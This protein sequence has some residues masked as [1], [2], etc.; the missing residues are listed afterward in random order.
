MKEI[1]IIHLLID[2]LIVQEKSQ[3]RR[4]NILKKKKYKNMEHGK[5]I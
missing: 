4:P 2:F 5:I 1:F 3:N